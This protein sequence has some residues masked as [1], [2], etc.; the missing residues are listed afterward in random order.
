MAQKQDGRNMKYFKNNTSHYFFNC[1][2]ISLVIVSVGLSIAVSRSE[3]LSL[4]HKDNKLVLGKE[5]KELQG[6][7]K[8]LEDYASEIK[9]SSPYS[10]S[11]KKIESIVQDIKATSENIDKIIEEEE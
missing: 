2:G 4:F 5:A 9:A 10:K 3:S 11:S 1:V 6:N 7:A 8:K